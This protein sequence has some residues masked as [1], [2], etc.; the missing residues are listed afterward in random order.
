MQENEHEWQSNQDG[1]QK[2]DEPEQFQVPSTLLSNVLQRLGLPPEQTPSE[3]SIDDLLLKLRS[4]TWE[5]RALALHALGRL[6]HPVSLNLLA[7]FLQDEDETVRATTIDVLG[8]MSKQVPL[9][10]LVEALHDTNWH[11]REAAVFAL[12]KQGA[13]VPK[14]VLMTALHD[15][16]GSVR[17]AASFVLH[18][19][20]A[21]TSSALYGQLRE[22]TVMQRELYD[23][24]RLNGKH[25]DHAPVNTQDGDW[26]GAF[27]EYGGSSTRTHAVNEQAQAYAASHYAP[28]S[29]TSQEVPPDEYASIQSSRN[30]KVTSYRLRGKAQKSWWTITIVVVAVL[31]LGLG[32]LS[33]MIVPQSSFG[34]GTKN[35]TSVVPVPVTTVAQPAQPFLFDATYARFMQDTL[36]THLHLTPQLIQEQLKRRGSLEAVATARG[37]SASDL[38]NAE[39]DAFNVIF[40]QATNAG[41]I[42][43]QSAS[44]WMAQLKSDSGLRDKIVISMLSTS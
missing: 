11:V 30:E 38:Y 1:T 7:P 14:E 37:V 9:H 24:A 17:E 5:E 10:W 43:P 2:D 16:D 23:P 4:G 12:A 27:M 13:R 31:F 35:A 21:E 20:T 8:T 33:T 3:Q 26:N 39:I 6:E 44:V 28:H 40:T 41:V 34:I 29:T 25:A 22:E 19:S 42:D 18:N 15:R 36:A 32:R